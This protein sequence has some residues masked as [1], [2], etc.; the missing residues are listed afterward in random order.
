MTLE[1]LQEK[2]DEDI[3]FKNNAQG[4][5]RGESERMGIRA[6]DLTNQFR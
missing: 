5:S 4:A 6:L 3:R 1:K 2:V